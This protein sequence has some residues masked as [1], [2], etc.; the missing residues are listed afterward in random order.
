MA[1]DPFYLMHKAMVNNHQNNV[2]PKLRQASA[3]IESEMKMV[4]P[5]HPK[6]VEKNHVFFER[7]F[8]ENAFCICTYTKAKR[9]SEID[10]NRPKSPFFPNLHDPGGYPQLPPV[11]PR[12]RRQR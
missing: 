3:N 9:S 4:E 11:Q 8:F 2:L 5:L 6:P 1:N 7:D 12:R 10:R